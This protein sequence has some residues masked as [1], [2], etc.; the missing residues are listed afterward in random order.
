MSEPAGLAAT[1]RLPL[2]AVDVGNSRVK[3]GLFD[4]LAAN[5]DQLPTPSR[6]L[7]LAP[8]HDSFDRI[9]EWL[10]AERLPLVPWWIGS[11]QR[12]VA[13]KLIVWLRD[14]GVDRIT[15]LAASDLPLTVELPRPDMVGI[16]RLLAALAA[17]RVR[18]Q[19]TPVVVVSLGTAIT[20]NLISAT[21]AFRGGAILPGI[22]TSAR[23]MHEFTD[24]LPLIDMHALDE[25]PPALGSDTISA[26]TSG[27]YWGAIGGV[28][29]LIELLAQQ[30]TGRPQV[31]LT[32]GAA[33]RV[34]RLI[35]PQAR[36]ER[37]L[38]LA[39]IA[40]VGGV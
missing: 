20:V 28:R 17:N 18:P 36:Y 14:R 24:L 11:V 33:P 19:N 10:G 31:V 39:G 29:H 9:V 23:A 26:M 25:P 8:Q 27:L 1:K 30:E 6:T 3:F 2:V 32:G 12:S 22:G 37:N 13:S 21:G 16:D 34:A 40:L 5:A 7:E 4:S 35:D 15:L 38:V